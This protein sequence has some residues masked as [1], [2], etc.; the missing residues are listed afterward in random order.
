MTLGAEFDSAY[1]PDERKNAVKL[2]PN[3]HDLIFNIHSFIELMYVL[4]LN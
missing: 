1:V 3:A 4:I 2:I